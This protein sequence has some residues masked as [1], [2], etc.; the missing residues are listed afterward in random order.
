MSRNQTG[1]I[2]RAHVVDTH[3]FPT[4]LSCQRSVHSFIYADFIQLII[5]FSHTNYESALPELPHLVHDCCNTHM[6]GVVV[7]ENSVHVTHLW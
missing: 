4:Q 6:L 5:A 3:F 7:G 2:D 1:N